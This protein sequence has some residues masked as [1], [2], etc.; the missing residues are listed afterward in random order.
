MEVCHNCKNKAAQ[1]YCDICR[2]SYCEQCDLYIHSFS[3]KNNHMRKNIINK[4]YQIESPKNKFT[5]DKNGFYIY[6]GNLNY[7]LYKGKRNP[8]F[9]ETKEEILVKNNTNNVNNSFNNKNMNMNKNYLSQDKLDFLKKTYNLESD[10][11]NKNSKIS[12]SSNKLSADETLNETD[13]ISLKKTKSFNSY[14]AKNNLVSLDEKLRLIKKISQLNCELSNTRS[15]I[16]Q[17]IDILNDHLQL[18]NEVNKK[19]MNELNYK[20]INEINMISSQKDTLIKHLKD[21]MNDQDEV[22]QKLLNKKKKLEENINE[23]KYLINKYNTEKN[24]YIKE[25]ENSENIYKEK[26][27]ELEQR[28]EIELAKIRND[29]DIELEKL[30]EKYRNTKLEYLNEIKKGN[31]IIEDFKLQG[32]KQVEVLSK[33]ID[34]LQSQNDIKN[35]ELNN[36]INTNKTLKQNLDDFNG[37]FDVANEKFKYNKE[38]KEKMKRIYDESKNEMMKRKKENEKLHGLMYGKFFFK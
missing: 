2:R 25:L 3:S 33:D 37:K 7:S 11:N 36:M 19:E 34:I 20:N 17:K 10:E 27:E 28:H 16:D 15:D 6:T 38:Q 4:S 13:P 14:M 12:I 22:I 23:N 9:E 35:E 31:D 8:L 21:V 1:Y 5:T 29:Y 24:N 26:K 30:N 32:Q 18:F